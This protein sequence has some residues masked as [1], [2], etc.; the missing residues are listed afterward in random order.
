VQ[1]LSTVRVPGLFVALAIGALACGGGGEID[2]KDVQLGDVLAGRPAT[3]RDGGE[4][5]T[6]TVVKHGSDGRV[7]S[8]TDYVD[9]LPTGRLE[10]WYENG[11][12]KTDRTVKLEKRPVG[13]VLISAGRDR[14]WCENGTLA[15]D[16]EFDAEGVRVGT[17]RE[18]TCSGKLLGEADYPAGG[19]KRW[20]ELPNG[21]VVLIEE[22]TRVESGGLDGVHRSFFPDGKPMIVE[23]WKD[24]QLDGIYEKYLADGTLAESGQHA[25]G[26][27]VGEWRQRLGQEEFLWDYDPANFVS[28]EHAGPFMQAAGID[29]DEQYGLLVEYQVDTAKIGEL[30][31]QGLVDVKKKL[32]V[33]RTPSSEFKTRNWTYPYVRASRAATALLRELGADPKAIDSSQRSR[34]HYCLNSLHR[35]CSQ[36]DVQQLIALGL[37]VKQA[38][39]VGNTPLHLLLRSNQVPEVSGGARW[40]QATLADVEPTLQALLAAGADV[41]ALNHDGVTPLVLALHGQMWDVAVFLLDKT[42]DPTFTTK[43][44]YN[45]VHLAFVVPGTSQVDLALTAERRTYVERAVAKGVDPR[46]KLGGDASLEEIAQRNGATEL[47][48]FL[49]QLK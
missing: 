23:N 14:R 22:G 19:F 10:E 3:L 9:G 40:R 11:Q 48:E 20:Q 12:Q 47:A 32:D 8:R 49:I 7:L 30:V 17:H 18:W 39:S 31:K 6:G 21:E 33:S 1:A 34:L 28:P 26:K 29:P 2:E 16:G 45:L 36:E 27:K 46:Q 15:S 5:V 42:Q 38:D 4:P 35:T 37:D 24:G 25:A 44:G 13:M 43:E 41:D